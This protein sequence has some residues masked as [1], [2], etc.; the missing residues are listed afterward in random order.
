MYSYKDPDR[1][2]DHA[3]ELLHQNNLKVCWQQKRDKLLNEK[4]DVTAFL[5]DFVENYPGSFP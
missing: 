4:I 1:A 3:I 2:L 5:I